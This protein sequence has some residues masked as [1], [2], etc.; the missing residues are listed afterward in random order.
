M[1]VTIGSIT[2][3]DFEVPS[4]VRFG[5]MQRL[6]EHRLGG[7]GRVIDALGSDDDD[8]SFAEDEQY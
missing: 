7:G 2:L 6:V 5:G 1:A 8:I 4:I 3:R